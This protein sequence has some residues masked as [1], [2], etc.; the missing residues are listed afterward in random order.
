[1]LEVVSEVTKYKYWNFFDMG[2]HLLKMC[3]SGSGILNSCFAFHLNAFLSVKV[4]RGLE[5]AW[6]TSK[7][8]DLV[9]GA[10]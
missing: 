1:M 7:E 4:K 5:R 9:F 3:V 6:N 8:S 2:T 10:P